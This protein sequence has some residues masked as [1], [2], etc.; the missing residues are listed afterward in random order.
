[1]PALCKGHMTKP[2][3]A[4]RLPLRDSEKAK[5][6]SPPQTLKHRYRA[7]G[8]TDGFPATATRERIPQLLAGRSA[9]QGILKSVAEAMKHFVGV[10]YR[11]KL[12]RRASPSS[13]R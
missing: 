5:T 1:M 10:I 8:T 11:S 6:G 3:V 13:P 7:I 12:V 2:K 4:A 9:S